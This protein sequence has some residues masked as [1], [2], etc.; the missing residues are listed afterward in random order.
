MLSRCMDNIGRRICKQSRRLLQHSRNGEAVSGVSVSAAREEL[1]RATA[2]ANVLAH[3]ATK[4]E[5]SQTH[6]FAQ[7]K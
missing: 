5:T 4:E 7:T 1:T 6:L 3:T 2:L